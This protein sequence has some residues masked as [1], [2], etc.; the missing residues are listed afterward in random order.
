MNAQ[1]QHLAALERANEIRT[2]RAEVKRSVVFAGGRQAG[3]RVLV[4][5]LSAP[6]E[7][8]LTAKIGDALC[9]PSRIGPKFAGRMLDELGIPW[10]RSVGM[11]TQ[12]QRWMLIGALGLLSTYNY[13]DCS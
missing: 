8:L 13:A 2:G 12:R 4:E 9:W 3:C 10:A 7:V 6:P 5:L 11:L 1:P